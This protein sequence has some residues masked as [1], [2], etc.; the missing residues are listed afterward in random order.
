MKLSSLFGLQLKDINFRKV[1]LLQFL[2]FCFGIKKPSNKIIIELK[3]EHKQLIDGIE[4][5]VIEKLT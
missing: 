1:I 3:Q 4:K 5:K 2:V